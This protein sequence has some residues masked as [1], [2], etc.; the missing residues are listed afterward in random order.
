[1]SKKEQVKIII[2][3]LINQGKDFHEITQGTLSQV[4]GLEDIS[5]TTI[6]RA[7]NEYKKEKIVVKSNY[8]ETLIKRK[9]YKYLDRYPRTSL[10]ELRDA[11]SEIPPSKVNEYHLFWTRK[12]EKKVENKA[13]KRVMISPRKLKEMVF[14]Y[15]NSNE[16]VTCEQLLQAFPDANKSSVTSYYG[17]W[18]KKKANHEKGKEGSLYQVVFGFLDHH[19]ETTIENLKKSFKD[20]PLRSLEVYHNLWLKKKKEDSEAERNQVQ[21]N[22]SVKA[23]VT[24]MDR[25][26]EPEETPSEKRKSKIKSPKSAEQIFEERISSQMNKQQKRGKKPTPLVAAEGQNEAETLKSPLSWE[27]KTSGVISEMQKTIED[28]KLALTALEVE[29]SMLKDNFQSK[30]IDGFDSMTAE[31]LSE[32]HEFVKTYVKGLQK[33]R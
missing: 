24:S 9:I 4:R 2:D 23:D 7:K 12:R 11:L 28:Q 19:P 33:K 17:H 14:S 3:E 5:K 26:S 29:Y 25:I 31:E 10:G 13:K 16:D 15:L 22:E 27:K 30:L 18:K 8:K 6:K 1:M 20:V 32:I 21:Q